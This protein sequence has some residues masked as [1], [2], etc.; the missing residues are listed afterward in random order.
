MMHSSMTNLTLKQRI[1][2]EKLSSIVI[3][4]EKTDTS[5]GSAD[6]D[7]SLLG[8]QYN[9]RASLRMEQLNLLHAVNS[10]ATSEHMIDKNLMEIY[11]RKYEVES[12]KPL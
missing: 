1:F 3:D 4:R 10:I 9:T 12:Q 2:A 7:L 11:R 8:N 5:D 6:E